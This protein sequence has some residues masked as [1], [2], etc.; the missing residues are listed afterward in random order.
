[1]GRDGG[2]GL[3]P[4]RTEV[5]HVPMP[6]QLTVS[7]RLDDRVP[8]TETVDAAGVLYVYVQ[9]DAEPE[10]SIG[11]LA[12]DHDGE[13]AA[14]HFRAVHDEYP[15]IAPLRSNFYAGPRK[16]LEAVRVYLLQ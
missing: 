16:F 3:S 10:Q 5:E 4:A 12:P 9:V 15:W 1:M 7:V 14:W 6:G 11:V 13:H 8:H 2:H